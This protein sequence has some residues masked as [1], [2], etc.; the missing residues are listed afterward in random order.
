MIC[1]IDCN[2][3]LLSCSGSVVEQDGTLQTRDRFFSCDNSPLIYFGD[4]NTEASVQAG[5]QAGVTCA[6]L[7][8]F[9]TPA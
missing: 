7:Q 1:S 2:T 8:I 5:A 3:G 4:A 9:T 6:N